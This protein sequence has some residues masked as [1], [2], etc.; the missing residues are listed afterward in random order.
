MR[1]TTSSP[2]LPFTPLQ[3]EDYMTIGRAGSEWTAPVTTETSF[4]GTTSYDIPYSE[5][6]TKP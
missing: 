6:Q 5:A 1:D 2:T 3:D 4:S